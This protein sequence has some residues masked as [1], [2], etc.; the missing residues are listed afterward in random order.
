M[1]AQV[2]GLGETLRDLGKVEPELRRTLNREIRNVLK[3]LV[4]DINARIPSTPPLSGMAHN[5]RT[6]WANRKTSVIKI[7]ARR[8][9]RNVNATSTATP[10]NVVRIVTRG[11]P[12]AIVDMAGKAGGSSSRR[13]VKYQ[14]P[15]FASALNAQL[16]TASRFMWRDIETSLGPTIAEMEKVVDDVVRQANRQLIRVRL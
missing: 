4:T 7:D 13:D 16:G 12:V 2:K 8:P 6:G 5:G 1:S 9:R 3:P 14:R 10:V 11:A 15:N